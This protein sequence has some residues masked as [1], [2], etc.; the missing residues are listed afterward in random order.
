MPDLK[1]GHCALPAFLNSSYLARE[2]SYFVFRA[3]MAS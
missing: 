3:S 1:S 2:I